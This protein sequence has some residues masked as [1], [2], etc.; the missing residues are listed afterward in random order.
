MP[1]EDANTTYKLVDSDA[2]INEPPGLWVDNVPSK[3][4]DLVPHMER[5]EKGHAW[6]MEGV[7][8][9]INFGNNVAASIFR[10]KRSAWVFWEDTPKGGYEPAARLQDMDTDM[11][12]AAVLYPT[13]RISQLVIGTKDPDLHLAMV[14]TYNDWLIDYCSYDPSRLGALPLLP[15]RGVQQAL[16]ELERVADRTS[17]AG[18]LIGCFPHGDADIMS[19]DDPLWRAIGERGLPLHVHVRLSSD[20]PVDMYAPERISAGRAAGDL[21]FLAAPPVMVQFLI[22]GVF[23]RIP[24]LTVVLGEV[25]GGWVPYVKEQMD[26]RFRRRASGPKARMTPLPSEV[27]H[28]HFYYTYITDHYAI[29]N[30]QRVGIDRLMWSSDFPHTG[31]D[32]PDS[33][34]TIDADF[35]DVPAEEKEMILS[36]NAMRLY[37]FGA[38]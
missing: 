37:R 4:R 11:V 30:R 19:D 10:T 23:D 38:R 17:V 34:R 14:R 24:N 8:D 31:S 3:Y 27:I 35:A 18:V 6:V 36:G 2:H 21:R 7:P 28:E 16:D 32:W 22:S 13:P 1:L 29:A 12:D 33:W 15:N 20:L 25:D 5:F 26:N 9:P